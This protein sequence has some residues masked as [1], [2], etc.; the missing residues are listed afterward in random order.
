VSVWWPSP[1]ASME[2]AGV[3]DEGEE[4]ALS[5]RRRPV[6][7]RPVPSILLEPQRLL[8]ES[9]ATRLPSCTCRH[10][11]D[12]GGGPS[13]GMRSRSGLYRRRRAFLSCLS[14]AAAMGSATSAAA[15]ENAAGLGAAQ[16]K[17]QQ[18]EQQQEHKRHRDEDEGD[19]D[20]GVRRLRRSLRGV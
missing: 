4:G 5:S 15:H 6:P 20:E 13:V 12:E 1:C 19:E 18:Q 17:Q 11:H 14:C 2:G 8:R 10:A 3:P 16:P 9:V 7:S